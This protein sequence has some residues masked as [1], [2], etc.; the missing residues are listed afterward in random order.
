MCR[1][2][3]EIHSRLVLIWTYLFMH[4]A[5]RAQSSFWLYDFS[6]LCRPPGALL[7]AA[8]AA[9]PQSSHANF[10]AS[11]EGPP[12]GWDICYSWAMWG[13][14]CTDIL[15][16]ASCSGA[17]ASAVAWYLFKCTWCA[18]SCA[19]CPELAPRLCPEKSSSALSMSLIGCTAWLS[20]SSTAISSNNTFLCCKARSFA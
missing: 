20:S 7:A 10:Q 15:H 11:R 4:F 18:A 2:G 12:S 17:L 3:I 1:H 13:S 9:L 19:S 14:G 5:S 6:F 8:A 16:C